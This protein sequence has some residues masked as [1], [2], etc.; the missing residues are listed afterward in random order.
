MVKLCDT[1]ISKYKK[2]DESINSNDIELTQLENDENSNSLNSNSITNENTLNTLKKNSYNYI[3][4]NL[5]WN[6]IDKNIL[7]LISLQVKENDEFISNY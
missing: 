1:I 2:L 7:K 3:K 6:T 4:L 5:N